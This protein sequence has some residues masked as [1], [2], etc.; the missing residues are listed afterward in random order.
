MEQLE[1][2][3]SH[4]E[5]EAKAEAEAIAVAAKAEYEK[6]IKEAEAEAKKTYDAII[7]EQKA[8]DIKTGEAALSYIER[9]KRLIRLRA[10]TEIIE[11]T[12]GEI[13]NSVE[14]MSSTEYESYLLAL[15]KN[16]AEI[17]KHGKIYFSAKGKSML[18]ENAVKQ[19]NLMELDIEEADKDFGLGFILKYK[20]VEENCTLEAIIREKR[21]YLTDIIAKELF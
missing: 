14:N 5:D 15:V 4:I 9:E 8:A 16:K 7:E 11:K 3:I 6:I 19:L 13:L 1:K 21:D 20:D 17:G 12:L 18:S 10:K 2:I